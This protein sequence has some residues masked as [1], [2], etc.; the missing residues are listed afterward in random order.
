MTL[1]ALS[2]PH[3]GAPVGLR[4]TFCGYCR[5]PIHVRQLLQIDASSEKRV[6]DFTL[7]AVP[8]ALAN[9]EAS[10][11]RGVGVRVVLRAGTG[12]FVPEG[13]P[14]RNVSAALT[15][16]VHDPDSGLDVGVRSTS[17]GKARAAYML[18]VRPAFGLWALFRMITVPGRAGARDKL[19][20]DQGLPEITGFDRAMKVE[21]RA[22]DALLQ[23]WLNDKL[24]GRAEDPYFG[25]GVPQWGASSHG[26][27]SRATLVSFEY[28]RL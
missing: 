14:C 19:G 17:L 10:A 8:P 21:L 1:Q 18:R 20:G 9:A 23:V 22:A 28:G 3:C 26:K 25:F 16:M 15:G 5:A 2:C 12:L 7:G 13:Q 4:S 11:V 24:V 6:V 27:P